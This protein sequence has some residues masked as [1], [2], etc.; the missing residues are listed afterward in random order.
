VTSLQNCTNW[1]MSKMGK[2]K[3]RPDV[4]NY[5][6]TGVLDEVA[7]KTVTIFR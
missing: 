5:L 2:T 3:D 1:Q 6:Y 4:L 7:P